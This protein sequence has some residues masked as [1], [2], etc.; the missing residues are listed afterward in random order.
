MKARLEKLTPPG[1]IDAFGIRSTAFQA[2]CHFHAEA[3]IVLIEAGNGRRLVGDRLTEFQP[4]DLVLLGGNLPHSYHSPPSPSPVRRGAARATVVH[5]RWERL[6]DWEAWG[7]ELRHLTRLHDQ[8]AAGLVFGASTYRR[9]A[10]LLHQ[11]PDAPPVARLGIL[12]EI[13]ELMARATDRQTIATPGAAPPQDATHAARLDRVLAHIFTRFRE[14]ITLVETAQVAHLTP[15]AFSRFFRRATHKTFVRF[16]NELRIGCA[17]RLLLETDRT[18]AD[19]AFASG[20]RNLANFNRRFLEYR[21]CPP[22]VFRRQA[23]AIESDSP[24]YSL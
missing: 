17:A 14:P 22:S 7:L 20:F 23:R 4:G 10:P 3:E 16:V 21:A 6:L 9:V 2:A 1:P 24:G 11:L 15:A 19:I 12:L 13:L 5:F 8:A 18:I